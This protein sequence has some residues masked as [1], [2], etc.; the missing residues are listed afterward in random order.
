MSGLDCL[1]KEGLSPSNPDSLAPTAVVNARIAPY[2]EDLFRWNK[3]TFGTQRRTREVQA[4][5]PWQELDQEDAAF[6]Q[7][8]PS[9]CLGI[10]PELGTW[11]G[12]K[13]AFAMRLQAAKSGTFQFLLD[14]PVLGPSSRFTRCYGSAWL[15]RLSYKRTKLKDLLLR[16]LV[17][18]GLVFRFF[19]A[20]KDHNGYLMATNELYDG[21]L[22]SG[23][24]PSHGLR[25]Y[26]SFLDFFSEHNNLKSNNNQTIAKWAARTAL[27]LSNSI[28]GTHLETTQIREE[29]DIVSSNCPPGMKPPSE[30]DMTDGCGMANFQFFHLLHEHLGVWKETPIAIQ[31]RVGGA[32]GLVLLH[33]GK[34]ENSW[35]QPCIKIKHTQSFLQNPAHRIIDV[36]RA[37]HMQSPIQVSREMIINLSDNGVPIDSMNSTI[38]P[39]LDWDSQ[40]AMPQLW[41]A[42]SRQGNVMAARMARES[43]WTARACGVQHYDHDDSSEDD[44]DSDEVDGDT[45]FSHSTAWWGDDI[46]GCPSSLEETAMTFLDTGF[47]PAT[48][49]VLAEKLHII[50]KKAVKSCIK[51]YRVTIPMSC[52]ALVV[53]DV[54]GVLQEGEIHL[55]SSQRCLLRPDGQRTDR[56]F[57]DVLVTRS[58]C[59]LPTDVQRVKAVFRPELDDYV[60]VI[61][62]S[63]KGPRSLASML[64]TGDY[65]G[66]RVVCIWQ[67]GI[68]E[69]FSNA[70]AKYMEPPANLGDCFHVKN[71]TVRDF[72]QRVPPTSPT[73]GQI[74]ELQGIL[75]APLK[76]LYVVGTYSSMHDNAIYSLGYSHPTTILLAWIYS[77]D[78]NNRQYGIQYAP[79]WKMEPGH[80]MMHQHYLPRQG[81]PPFVM[82]VLQAAMQD[83][84]NEQ[85]RRIDEHFSALPKVKDLDLIAPWQDAEARARE[86]LANP[87]QRVRD[88]GQAQQ[89]ALEAIKTHVVRVH[90]RCAELLRTMTSAAAGEGDTKSG[91][92]MGR[93][94]E[95][96]QD[97]LRR[98]SREFAAGPAPA[99]TFV[100][101]QE[102]VARLRASYAYLYD[103]TRR[104]GGTRIPW[105]VAMRELG[106]IKLRARKDLKPISQEFYEKMSMR[107]V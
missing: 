93:S 63:I 33:P 41:A 38:S 102:E 18:N 11:F 30:M 106:L 66:D 98:M 4:T 7:H 71:E 46:S 67:P 45:S 60:D 82:D 34:E 23:P 89:D 29:D 101:G 47:H 21:G 20:N 10:T 8:G 35:T 85:L 26:T 5:S 65:D 27:G 49:P 74:G 81:L 78:R 52:S 64:G 1:R 50:A 96:R 12:G 14:H 13:V 91:G 56:I 103:W 72:L 19:Y 62:F 16:P 59:K 84:S 43:A 73:S 39:L 105:N 97:R 2:V 99:E 80:M 76:D 3:N 15:I 6:Q 92:L 70:N 86:L 54:L 87:E 68:V 94:I 37:A 51:K 95:T 32:K 48:N 42:V 40:D 90:G 75:M 61:M 100:F 69:G 107:R 36:L 25:N 28:P 31:C 9:S 53:P 88:V 58:P 77:Q 17:L 44:D 55:K 83:V 57:G 22:T 79:P 24:S 104:H